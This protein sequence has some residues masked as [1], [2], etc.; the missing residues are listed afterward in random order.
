MGLTGKYNFSGIKTMG[1]SGLRLALASSPYTAW[2]LKGGKATDSALE[3]I[4][5]WLANQGL[6]VL[7][8]GAIAVE[9]EL[10]QR[11]LDWALDNAFKEIQNL[12]GHDKLTPDQKKEID[13]A[14]I[15]AARKFIV[16]SRPR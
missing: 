12:G 3:A 1:A 14:V 16:I 4:A 6:I 8:L 2:L 15:I 11:N 5:N 9:G 10:D 7:N 13:D